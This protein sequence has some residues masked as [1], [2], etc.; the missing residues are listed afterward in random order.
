MSEHD[1]RAEPIPQWPGELR[2]AGRR[3]L[4]VRTDGPAGRHPERAVYIHGLGGSSLDW[5][6]LMGELAPQVEG[7][8]PDLP[9]F[10][11]SPPPPDGDYSVDGHAAAAAEVVREAGAP[12]HL[13]GNSLGAAV[14]VRL[15]AEHP[16]LVRTLTLIA[17]ALPDPWPRLVPYQM[18]GALIPVLGPALYARIQSRPAQVRAQGTL[19]SVYYDPSSAPLRRVLELVD[20]ERHRE[21]HHH[22]NEAVLGS[23][24]GIVAEY[25]RRGRRSLWRQ[26]ER[27]PCPTLLVYCDSDRFVA[28]RMSLRAA[29]VFRHSHLVYLTRAG[30]V[31]M[32]E[33][34]ARVAREVRA[35]LRHRDR[36]PGTADRL[37]SAGMPNPTP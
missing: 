3:R 26:A 32:R 28:P 14:A 7:I 15:S 31:P 33:H 36:F 18:A 1:R 25:L 4:F 17:P 29:R 30:H 2:G 22:A 8:A 10:G 19:S 34:P 24:R 37:P 27:I 35:F 12:V 6:D 16:E 5:T 9:G 13:V 20:A 23:L 11:H 21:T